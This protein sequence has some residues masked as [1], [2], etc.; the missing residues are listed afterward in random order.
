[1]K[2]HKNGLRGYFL[3]IPDE[4]RTNDNYIF[5]IREGILILKKYK[6][7]DMYVKTYKMRLSGG[8]NGI[9]IPKKVIDLVGFS[10]ESQLRFVKVEEDLYIHAS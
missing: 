2:I 5:F 8:Y 4:Y 3:T 7:T 10:Q 1:M 9:S 6:N